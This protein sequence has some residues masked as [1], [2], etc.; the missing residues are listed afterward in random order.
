M[1]SHHPAF[2]TVSENELPEFRCSSI[3]LRHR[4]TGCEVWKLT[5]D[6]VE[7][8]F[9]FVFR[10]PPRDATGVAHIVE[11][12]VL[13]GSEA[14]PVKDAF[15]VLSRRSLATFLN[16]LTWPDKTAYPAASAVKADFFNLL[17][18]YGDAVFHPLLTRQTFM[19]EAHHL[20]VDG[21]GALIIK[22]VVYNEMRG[23][24]ASPD[25]L[26]GT[27]SSTKLFSPGHPYSMDSGGDPERIRDLDYE[28][29]RR[30]WA[31]H[32]HPSNCRIF[33]HGDIDLLEELAFLE[34]HFLSGFASL[35][36]DA[37]G[38]DTAIPVQGRFEA[39]LRIDV[40]FPLAE[41][42]ESSSQVVVNWLGPQITDEL[43]AFGIEL[44]GEILL[45]HD[46]APLAQALRVSE[47]GEDLSPQ[48]GID[49]QFRQVILSAGLRGTAPES[50]A[51]VESLIIETIR[52]YV[53]AGIPDQARETALHSIAFANRE[54]RRGSSTF[55]LRLLFRALRGWI[56]GSP[57]EATLSFERALAGARAAMA[58]DPTWL[59]GLA[60]T[61]IIDNPH[62]TTVTVHPEAGLLESRAAESS[63]RMAALATSLG[64][65]GLARVRAEQEGL[66]AMQSATE[67]EELLSAIPM[68]RVT[69]LPRTIEVIHR[70][71]GSV[72][73]VALSSRPMFTN[74]IVYLELAFP[75]DSLPRE[76]QVWMPLFSRFAT[77]AGMEGMGWAK[78]AEA[79]AACSG[80]FSASLEA[81]RCAGARGQ[82]PGLPTRTFM[83]FRLKALAERFD[84]ALRLALSLLAGADT[85]DHAR[86]GDL[87]S[88]LGNDILSAVVP[89]G[90]SFATARAAAPWSP[91]LSIDESWRGTSQAA[92]VK[93]LRSRPELA[94]IA[95]ALG[96]IN[97]AV[98][99]RE[100]LCASLTADPGRI[101]AARVALEARLPLLPALL[102]S[103]AARAYP[104]APSLDPGDRHEAFTITSEVGFAAATLRGSSLEA[105]A[106]A[107]ESV[108]AHM[109]NRGA[110][111]DE[112]RV[113]GG[114]Y[115]ASVWVDGLE[116]VASFSTY[117]DPGPVASLSAFSRV[118]EAAAKGGGMRASVEAVIGVGGR[119]LKPL[120][121][122]EKS[123]VDF[124]RELFGIEDS[125][126]QA[127]R[128]AILATTE[129]ELRDAA[130]RL[131]A[132]YSR[133]TTV[134]ISGEADVQLAKQSRPETS[135]RGTLP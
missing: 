122:E 11:H 17:S 3:L 52:A 42:A 41:G 114:A 118:L 67:A 75:I 63:A 59:E 16:A 13:C 116:G 80:G 19:Q 24:Y 81:S 78:V 95:G 64:E 10:T 132:D 22:G 33:L 2:E 58:A 131:A 105:A 26:A 99:A 85:T 72:A 70:E 47:L 32:Y 60:H 125:A 5:A 56:H 50:E 89:A 94:D 39:P 46:G 12:S 38:P 49:T 74:G 23:D 86:V 121:P 120:L 87:L 73:G 98:F 36:P 53:D 57:P 103:L 83:L 119:D 35:G 90:N 48:C 27:A 88:E 28:G 20:E 6:E 134:L 92:F 71:S 113:K 76:V 112:I 111:W 135:L 123:Q 93:S 96:L 45:G 55:G 8:S 100:G 102:P 1:R 43:E 31:E 107:H 15:L 18:V 128:D 130:G 129:K 66:A 7:N 29:F 34:E 82:T 104:E 126:R 65:E 115:G 40:P 108:L 51:A 84:E 101:D 110:L 68:L 44:L 91:S 117:R 124:R 37:S 61:W 25:S 69:D 9:A 127:K 106:H 133:A 77:S 21:T 109:L 62:R 4:K 54:I 79:L 14:Y 30:F 97:K